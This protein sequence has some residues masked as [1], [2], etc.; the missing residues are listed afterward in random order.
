MSSVSVVSHVVS[1]PELL[2]EG[3]GQR[4]VQRIKYTSS[5]SG[6]ALGERRL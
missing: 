2:P 6:N 3:I 5:R 4:T 1:L